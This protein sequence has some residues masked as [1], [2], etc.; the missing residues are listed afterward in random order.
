M[1]DSRRKRRRPQVSLLAILLLMVAIAVWLACYRT[2]LATQKLAVQLP[3]LRSLTRELI[4]DDPS[5]LTTIG[6]N[7]EWTDD[8]D[9]E[10]WVPNGKHYSVC[11]ALEG[12]S[13]DANTLP[14]AELRKPIGFGKHKIQFRVDRSGDES[15]HEVWLDDELFLQATRPK[16]WGFGSSYSGY[17][18]ST[19][20]QYGGAPPWEL[21]RRQFELPRSEKPFKGFLE[22]PDGPGPG[23]QVW[24][25]EQQEPTPL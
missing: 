16:D 11:M 8:M 14:D 5:K 22:R 3:G 19:L 25:D 18:F 1:N 15:R 6:R 7:P 20:R 24:I 4:V 10:I 17:G 13:E 2:E 9:G 12:I 21:F 23:M